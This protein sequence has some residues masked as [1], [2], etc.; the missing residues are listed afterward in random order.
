MR[1]V[2]CTADGKSAQAENIISYEIT[3][4]V[5]AACDGLRLFFKADESVGEIVSV[6][7]FSG[8]ELIF[9]GLADVQKMTA[10]ADGLTCFIYARSTACLLVDNEAVPRQL[11]NPS[12][13]QL[14]F[15]N[16]R[17]FGFTWDLPEIYS[18]N[19]YLIS[20]GKSRFGAINDFVFAV[21]GSDIYVTPGDVIK[22]FEKSNRVKSLSDYALSRASLI[23]NRGEPISCVDYK[24]SA[25][26]S[27][28]YHYESRSAGNRGIKRKRL[29]NLSSVP[30][31]QRKT[32]AKK[33][34][35]RSLLDYVC[36]E[37]Q[38]CGECDLKLFDTVSAN[39]E[40]IGACGEFT[41][42]ELVRMKNKNG[43]KT[44]ALLKK[45][46]EEDF[47]NYVD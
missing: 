46:Q 39:I 41:V 27:Y 16:A 25:G 47:V 18:E 15:C 7:A 11:E 6:K 42:Y 45:S 23:I 9:S 12:A 29:Y 26:E 34:L 10:G 44:I 30:A 33:L 13:Q 31:W 5:G 24:I 14:C 40:E 36:L 22:V 21:Y 38:I 8:E 28:A 43:E 37:A 35:S 4:E 20:K 1:F 3:S 32:T 17:E 19:S 2:F